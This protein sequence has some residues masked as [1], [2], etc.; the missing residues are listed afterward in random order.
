MPKGKLE[1]VS[2]PEPE[3]IVPP[4]LAEIRDLIESIRPQ[5]SLKGPASLTVA[6]EKGFRKAQHMGMENFK[7]KG[8]YMGKRGSL[9]WQFKPED[10]ADYTTMEMTDSEAF[11]QLNGFK[12]A[13][14]QVL[15][16][17][18]LA[19]LKNMKNQ[20]VK[21]AEEAKLETARTSYADF[22]SW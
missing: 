8:V 11:K 21:E 16:E 7:L 14:N 10:V 1:K 22:G 12:E 6:S 18:S 15:S 4:E 5:V 13:M 2:V 3:P 19:W 9:V 20:K 17:E